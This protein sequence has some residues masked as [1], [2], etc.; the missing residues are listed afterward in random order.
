MGD[1]HKGEPDV[2]DEAEDLELQDE[3]AENVSGGGGVNMH[4]FQISKPVDKSSPIIGP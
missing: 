4:E 2:T 1:E 3:D